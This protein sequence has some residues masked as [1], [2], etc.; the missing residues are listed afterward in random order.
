[1]HTRISDILS[2]YE[3][4]EIRRRDLICGIAALTVASRAAAAPTSLSHHEMSYF[5]QAGGGIPPAAPNRG[6][7]MRRSRRVAIL[8]A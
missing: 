2:R 5:V 1:M 8:A 7:S 6:A 3:R 4:G